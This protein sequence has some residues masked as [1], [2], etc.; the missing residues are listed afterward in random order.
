MA[1]LGEDQ[2]LDAL[3]SSERLLLDL[4]RM[5][6]YRAETRMMP[7]VA[8]AQGAKT[9]PRRPLAELFHSAADIIP[10]PER[11]IL[12]VRILGT[13]STAGDAALAGLLEELTQTTTVY[14]GTELRM[15]YELPQIDCTTGKNGA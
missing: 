11:G 7:A 5:I 4:I 6:A 10:E 13:A 3:P 8:Q 9:R 1:E 15:V 12:R 2:K 14:P